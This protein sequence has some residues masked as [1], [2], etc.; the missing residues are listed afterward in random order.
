MCVSACVF[1]VLYEFLFSIQEGRDPLVHRICRASGA[2]VLH[3]DGGGGET[4]LS[5]PHTDHLAN[6]A[7]SAVSAKGS[8]R[9]RRRRRRQAGYEDITDAN[10]WIIL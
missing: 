10:V 6:R 1:V 9:K 2:G 5:G 3:E 8:R 7:P 4:S